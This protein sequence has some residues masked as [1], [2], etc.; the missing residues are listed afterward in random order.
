MKADMNGLNE[1]VVRLLAERKMTIASAESC[2]GGLFS[3]LVTAVAGASEIINESVV[4]YSNEAKIKYL[5][6]SESTLSRHGAVSRETAY[7][8]AQGLYRNT[9][10]DVTAAITGIAGPDGG[11]PEKPVGLV[12]AGICVRGDT[13]VIQMQNSGNR[14][15]VREKT[16]IQ[17]FE[18]IKNRVSVL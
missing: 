16:C 15:E 13:E 17:V 6:V 12:F 8:M 7:E 3:A 9:G 5:G 1:Q 2:T 14:D 11:T 18:A 10:A 4:T